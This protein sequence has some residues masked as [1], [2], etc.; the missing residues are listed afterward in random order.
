MRQSETDTIRSTPVTRMASRPEREQRFN[1]I[2]CRVDEMLRDA[3][4]ERAAR[5]IKIARLS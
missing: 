4:A 3:E 1:Q 2:H 5:K